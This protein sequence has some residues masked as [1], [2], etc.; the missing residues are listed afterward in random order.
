MTEYENKSGTTALR[1]L[2]YTDQLDDE[3]LPAVTWYGASVE[4]VTS[5][6]LIT[7]ILDAVG[8][9]DLDKVEQGAITTMICENVGG[10][11]FQRKAVRR[12]VRSYIKED[13]GR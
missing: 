1:G 9:R 8:F 5:A 13:P 3:G 7:A 4:T 6:N 2:A 11:V 12:I 10:R